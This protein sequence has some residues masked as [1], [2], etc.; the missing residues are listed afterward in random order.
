M[1][2]IKEIEKGKEKKI[3]VDNITYNPDT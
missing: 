3:A 2:L 1:K